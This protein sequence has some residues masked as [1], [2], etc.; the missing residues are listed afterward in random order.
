M[1]KP[2]SLFS[3]RKRILAVTLVISFIFCSLALRL[4]V[5]QIINGKELQFKATDQWTRDLAIVAPRGDILDSTGSALIMSTFVVVRWSQQAR[6][7][8][9]FHVHLN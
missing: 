4:F 9:F 8:L 2:Y 6:L 3:F 5:I 1:Q 7:P